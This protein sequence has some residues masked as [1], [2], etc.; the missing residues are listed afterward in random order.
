MNAPT[1]PGAG[2]EWRFEELALRIESAGPGRCAVEVRRSPF[3]GGVRHVEFTYSRQELLGLILA[4]QE[5]LRASGR[6]GERAGGR[7]LHLHRAA[8]AAS[9]PSPAQVGDRLFQALFTG[10]VLGKLLLGL[11]RIANQPD[12][13]LRIR[14]EFDPSLPD[15]PEITSLP[16]ELIY[17]AETRDHLALNARTPV[18]RYLEV[19]RLMAPAPLVSSLRILAAC[20]RPRGSAPLALEREIEDLG[21]AWKQLPGVEIELLD[22]ATLRGLLAKL[23]SAS[24]HVLH[25][26][27]HGEFEAGTGE[28]CLIFEDERGKATPVSGSLL[29]ETVKASRD[30]RLVVLNACDSARLPRQ[31]GQDPFSGTASALIMAGIPAVVAMQ[32]P[33]SDQAAIDFSRRFYEAL[34][35]GLPVD[36]AAAAGRLAVYLTSPGC[37]EWAIPALFMSIPDGRILLPPAPATAKK[38]VTGEPP[39]NAPPARRRQILGVVM[40]LAFVAILALVARS[41]LLAARPHSG[42]PRV[43]AAEAKHHEG[44]E[45]M[46]CGFV[47]GAQYARAATGQ[48]TFLDFERPFPDEAFRAVIWSEDRDRFMD[49]PETTYIRRNLCVTGTIQLF[50]ATPEIIVRNPAQLSLDTK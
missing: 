11:G 46:V 23:T 29:G 34:A 44:E 28:G 18:V 25:F 9:G 43:A 24:F 17:R 12:T 4:M 42:P 21:A 39:A 37:W 8:G 27:G 41:F 5:A 19:P 3:G 35:S 40:A 15:L 33:I 7:D 50:A 6:Q 22:H 20:S 36:A 1:G 16:W 48:P 26:M 2:W 14:L 38:D 31:R 30:L 10:G 47:A 13:G 49:Q 32:F 45:A